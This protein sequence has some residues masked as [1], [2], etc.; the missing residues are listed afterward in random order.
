VLAASDPVTAGCAEAVREARAVLA[1]E[2]VVGVN[3][4]GLATG[5]GERAGAE[6]KAAIGAAIR[7]AA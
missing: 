5:R 3:L 7:S 1:V 2:G 6:I 4:S